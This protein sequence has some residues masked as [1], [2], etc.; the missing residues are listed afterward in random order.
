MPINTA[1][2][3]DKA[4]YVFILW[5]EKFDE[6]VATLFTTEARRLGLCVK[7]IGLTGVQAAGGNGMIITADLTLGQ[8]MPL[9]DKAICVVIPCSPAILQRIEDDPR[10]PDFFQQ[11]NRNQARFVLSRAE[12]QQRSSLHTLPINPAHLAFYDDYQNLIQAIRS[13]VQSLAMVAALV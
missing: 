8:A 5:G 13:H 9:A 10:I 12:A 6:D 1:Q 7:I 2:P 11:A 3:A 4:H